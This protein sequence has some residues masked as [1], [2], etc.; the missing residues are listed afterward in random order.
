MSSRLRSVSQAFVCAVT[1]AV[2]W[3]ACVATVRPHELLVGALAVSLSTFFSIGVIRTLPLHFRPSLVNLIQAWRVPWYVVTGAGEMVLVLA[4]DFFGH[5]ADSLF[6]AA[7]WGPVADTG[8]DT[9]RRVLAIGYTTIAPNF[10]IIGIDCKRS[11][12]LFHQV[13]KSE[14]PIMTQRLGAESKE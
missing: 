10:I 13:E 11:Q 14:V 5:H 3:V 1:L 12:M 7:P 2:F 9:A 8:V 6:R 4:R